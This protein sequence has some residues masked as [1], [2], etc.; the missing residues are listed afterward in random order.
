MQPTVRKNKKMK[1]F[2]KGQVVIPA[3]IR[4]TYN[5]S[6]GDQIEFIPSEEG[7]L[8]KPA[9]RKTKKRSL[10]EDLFGVF[11]DYSQNKPFLEKEAVSKATENG[12]KNG[13]AE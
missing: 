11:R 2:P 8:L 6:I 9:K 3:D 4:R 10:T 7:I 12:F 13:W 5:I 1:V